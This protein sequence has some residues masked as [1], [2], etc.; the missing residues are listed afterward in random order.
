MLGIR[1]FRLA[2][3]ILIGAAVAGCSSSEELGRRI[4]GRW[5]PDPVI[6]SADAQ[7]AIDQQLHVLDFIIKDAKIPITSPVNDANWFYVAEWGFNI[8]RQ[9]CTVYLDD[10]FRLN[11][12][13]LR[14]HDIINAFQ[15]AASGIVTAASPHNAKALSVLAAAFGLTTGLNDA[16]LQSYLFTEAPGLIAVKVKDL[17]DS[18]QK[19]ITNKN[20]NSAATA[21][22]AL[23]NYYNIC[24]PQSIEG[25]ILQKIATSDAVTSPPGTSSPPAA[26]KPATAFTAAPGSQSATT[27]NSKVQL[28]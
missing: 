10:L 13:K 20:V 24:L 21:Y 25:V 19:T 7:A 9:D 26:P 1:L 3:P 22:N 11:R 8:G 18:Y 16:I 4:A 27:V 12:E 5:G 28:R 15:V 6:R 14:N 17:Q 23:Q 2:C